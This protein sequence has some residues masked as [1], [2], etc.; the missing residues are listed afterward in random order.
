MV[1]V[2][3]R[4]RLEREKRD[5]TLDQMVVATGIGRVYLEALE[6]GE[7]QELPGKAF[8]KLYIRAYAEVFEFDP[9]PWIEEYD[10]ERL[11]DPAVAEESPPPPARPRPVEAALA[12]WREARTIERPRPETP[13]A[14]VSEP[15]PPTLEAVVDPPLPARRTF[16]PIAIVA[17]FVAVLAC[18]GA[19][20]LIFRADR[21]GST[22]PAAPSPKA[23]VPEPAPPLATPVESP[24]PPS[25]RPVKPILSRVPGGPL[26]VS[27]FGVGRRVVNSRLDGEGSLFAP[28]DRVSFATRVLGGGRGDVVRHVWI[29]DGKVEQSIALRLGGPDWRTHSNKTLGKEGEWTVEARDASGAVLATAAFTC[30]PRA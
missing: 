17:V 8:G 25:P 27:E 10:R 4:L 3:E 11:I 21:T 9:Q 29:R 23:Y 22:T 15:V 1:S 28:G 7:I 12:R 16:R 18:G 5:T 6:N 26:T 30:R 19:A 20:W 2:G 13:A 24:V 14:P